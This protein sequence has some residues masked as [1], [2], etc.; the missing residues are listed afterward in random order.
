MVFSFLVAIFPWLSGGI[1]SRVHVRQGSTFRLLPFTELAD[2][3]IDFGQQFR[4][5]I[6]HERA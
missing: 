2:L 6:A 1:R 4:Q 5:V 3:P